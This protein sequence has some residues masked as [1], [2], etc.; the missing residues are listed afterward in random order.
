MNI[1]PINSFY[2]P[3]SRVNTTKTNHSSQSNNN[4]YA[5]QISFD[6][7]YSFTKLK[8]MEIKKLALEVSEGLRDKDLPMLV[9]KEVDM[10][11]N[12]PLRRGYAYQVIKYILGDEKMLKEPLIKSNISNI[13]NSMVAINYNPYSYMENLEKFTKGNYSDD[14]TYHMTSGEYFYNMPSEVFDDEDLGLTPEIKETFASIGGQE[15]AKK[16]LKTRIINPLRHPEAF[17][18]IKT[19]KGVILYGPPGTGKSLLARAIANMCDAYYEAIDGTSMRDSYVGETEQNW[20]ELF[21]RLKQNQPS[22]L[23]VDEADALCRKRGADCNVYGDDEQNKFLTLMSELEKND[24]DIYVILATNR[25]EALDDAILR[26]RRF[27]IRIEILPPQTVAETEQIFDIHAKDFKFEDGFD[28]KVLMNKLFA[29]NS[30]GADIAGIVT[31]AYHEALERV[32]ANEYM[33]KDEPIPDD[34]INSIILSNIDFANAIKTTMLK[35]AQPIGYSK[36]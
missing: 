6:A 23:F 16:V 3:Y 15:Y 36:H 33:D 11:Y 35:K 18:P 27:G 22:I 7:N 2:R 13:F 34:V 21:K 12:T 28:K 17:L 8:P 1:I 4:S 14:V 10:I 31:E 29:Q 24:Y 26:Q 5:T 32:G 9:E 25:F 20:E 19:E 30:T